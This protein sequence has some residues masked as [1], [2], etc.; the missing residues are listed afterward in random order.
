MIKGYDA[1][2]FRTLLYILANKPAIHPNFFISCPLCNIRVDT[3]AQELF[4]CTQILMLK[5]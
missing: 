5:R 2:M 1:F 4:Y 3:L